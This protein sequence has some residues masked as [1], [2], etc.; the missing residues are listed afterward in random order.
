MN[1]R[2]AKLP[3][4]GGARD[5]Q[6][7]MLSN[8][9]VQP[10]RDARRLEERSGNST[11]REISK[12]EQMNKEAPVVLSHIKPPSKGEMINDHE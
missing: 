5:C 9:A 3:A 8:R 6:N 4:D 12:Y 11:Q 7:I 2:R 1:R 10:M